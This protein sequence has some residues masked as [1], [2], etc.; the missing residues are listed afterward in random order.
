M[1]VKKREPNNIW[2]QVRPDI[3]IDDLIYNY[4]AT[5]PHEDIPTSDR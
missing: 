5:H 3:D 4:E 1:T 2:S